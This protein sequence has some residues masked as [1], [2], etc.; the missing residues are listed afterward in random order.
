MAPII[1]GRGG[2]AHS[3]GRAR[4]SVLCRGMDVSD[5]GCMGGRRFSRARLTAP[6]L[7][8]GNPMMQVRRRALRS[9]N[10]DRRIHGRPSRGQHRTEGERWSPNARESLDGM[11]D[12]VRTAH[13][14]WAYIHTTQRCQR[15]GRPQTGSGR[16]LALEREGPLLASPRRD[17]LEYLQQFRVQAKF[18]IRETRNVEGGASELVPLEPQRR[19]AL[20]PPAAGASAR[21]AGAHA[22]C[23][24]SLR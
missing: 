7:R 8:E 20:G 13:V 5:P 2:G 12:I 1:V 24:R 3:F 23:S 4:R 22:A 19:P 18:E 14:A 21:G 16:F 10:R 17:L 15:P 9:P 11:R 6:P